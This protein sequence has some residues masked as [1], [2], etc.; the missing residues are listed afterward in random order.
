MKIF[1]TNMSSGKNFISSLIL[2]ILLFGKIFNQHESNSHLKNNDRREQEPNEK[3]KD[4]DN[5]LEFKE[6]NMNNKNKNKNE[7]ENNKQVDNK[8]NIIEELRKKNNYIIKINKDSKNKLQK[9]NLFYSI[10]VVINIILALIIISFAIYK[11]Y[12]Y[13][14]NK[15]NNNILEVSISNNDSK[16]L[17]KN[18]YEDIGKDINKSNLVIERINERPILYFEANNENLN[19]APTYDENKNN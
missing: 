15:R 13:I 16:I 10:M 2:I 18:N 17:Q 9:Y 5:L 12:Y 11:L 8:Q 6:H 4:I 19:D 1:K 14:S 3:E 7:D